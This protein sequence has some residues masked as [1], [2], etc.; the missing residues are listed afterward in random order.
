MR[1]CLC[2]V[3]LNVRLVLVWSHPARP[4]IVLVGLPRRTGLAAAL[5]PA[6]GWFEDR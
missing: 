2:S 1:M 5:K 3:C 6:P 4:I